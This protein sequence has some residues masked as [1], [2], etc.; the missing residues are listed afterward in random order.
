MGKKTKKQETKRIPGNG[1][2][3]YCR[4]ST[5]QQ[6]TARQIS[7]LKTYADNRGW[8]VLDIIQEKIS[9]VI[10]NGNR[11]GIKS[12]MS[13][14]SNGDVS[15]ILVTEISRLGR[16]AYDVQTIIEEMA[17]R[18][19]S[20]VITT[21]SIET[22]DDSGKRSPMVDLMLA[23]ITQFA[24]MERATLIDRINSG[25]NEARK[26]GVRLGRPAGNESTKQFLARYKGAVSDFKNGISIRKVEKIYG[27]SHGTSVKIRRAVMAQKGDMQNQ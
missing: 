17:T 11:D 27:F 26:N 3:L 5:N 18:G 19:I 8:V 23:I 24:Q 25:L 12:L 14:V 2:I 4:V 20:I 21:L 22:L 9:G 7:D 15:R 13:R 16:K 1:C 10:S 6:E